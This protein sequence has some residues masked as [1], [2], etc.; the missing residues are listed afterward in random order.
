MDGVDRNT[1]ERLKAFIRKHDIP[2]DDER[3]DRMICFESNR[4]WVHSQVTSVPTTVNNTVSGNFYI[5]K[6]NISQ[7]L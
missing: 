6:S 5:L 1:R 2:I 3:L 4:T 7:F